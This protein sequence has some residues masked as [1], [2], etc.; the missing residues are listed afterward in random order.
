LFFN[1]GVISRMGPRRFNVNLSRELAAR[2]VASIRFDLSGQGDS[3]SA[4]VSK[5]DGQR[6]VDEL[7]AGMDFLD[8]TLGV[9]E[10]AVFGICSGA[11]HALK[12]ASRDPRIRAVWL[13]DPYCYPTWRTYWE[14]Y[15][16]EMRRRPLIAVA[17]I[18][19]HQL[20]RARLLALR[21]ARRAGSSLSDIDYGNSRPPATHFAAALNG[22]VARGVHVYLT[23]T[24]SQI[25]YFNYDQQLRDAFPDEP[26]VASVRCEIR[27][28]IDHH[29]TRHAMQATMTSRLLQWWDSWQATSREHEA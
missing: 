26:F 21:L 3:S 8:K 23:Y 28:D 13:A 9:R 11:A 17:R 29:F 25:W 24:A 22:L 20:L 10:F 18:A 27:R 6:S 4:P 2:G 14:R 16:D 12:A 7:I 1:A 19:W 15:A 5:T